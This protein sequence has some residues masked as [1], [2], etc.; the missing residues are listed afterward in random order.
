MNAGG[1]VFDGKLMG[2]DTAVFHSGKQALVV[3]ASNG[4]FEYRMLAVPVPGNTF[5]VRLFIRISTEFGNTDHDTLYMGSRVPQ[6]TYNGDE[7]VEISEQS[8]Q[9]LLNKNDALYSQSGPGDPAGSGAAGPKLPANT[10]LCMETLF[11]G[12]TNSVQVYSEGELLID[13]KNYG[14]GGAYKTFRFGYES[15]H[16]ARSIWYDDLVVSAT[17]VGCP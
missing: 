10:W 7:A 9:L 17:R 1:N 4:G 5:W 12:A 15:F 16:D 2:F 6:G 3:P 14:A 8:N 11:D 13:A